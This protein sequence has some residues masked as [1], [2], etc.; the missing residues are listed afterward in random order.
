MKGIVTHYVSDLNK[1]RDKLEL[2]RTTI[3]RVKIHPLIKQ[4]IINDI[5]RCTTLLA[6][7]QTHEN[8]LGRQYGRSN[9]RRTN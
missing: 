1:I 8:K 3:E 5:N 7:G 4:D 2:M 6:K 9:S